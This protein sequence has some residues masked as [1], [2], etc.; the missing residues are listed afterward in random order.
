MLG[1]ID[2]GTILPFIAGA[3]ARGLSVRIVGAVTKSSTYAI[4]SRP[5]I[6]SIKGLKGKK[7]GI[8]S[9]GSS[10]DYAVYAALSR[11]GLD[12]NRD[13]TILTVGG[14]SAPRLAALMSRS[15][16]ATVVTSP[17]EQTAEKQGLKTLVSVR[18]SPSL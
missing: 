14:G 18:D 6:E 5:E 15:I 17:F 8:N 10:A 3:S 11:S 4:I 2:Y 7:V 16:D 1:E 9:F 12:P 13:V